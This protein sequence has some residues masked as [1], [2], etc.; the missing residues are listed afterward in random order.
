MSE[1]KKKNEWERVCVYGVY[2]CGIVSMSRKPSIQCSP[3]A[4]PQCPL[5]LML[6]GKGK[7]IFSFM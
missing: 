7:Y 3:N 4:K 5:L 2:V 1:K 6:T